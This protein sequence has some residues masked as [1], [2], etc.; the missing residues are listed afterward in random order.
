MRC[1]R[2]ARSRHRLERHAFFNQ[3]VSAGIA[4]TDL[5][6]RTIQRLLRIEFIIDHGADDLEV[7]L[8]LHESAHDTEAGPEFA[9]IQRQSGDDGVVRSFA[10]RQAMR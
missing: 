7:P 5:P 8:G 2:S 4:S 3:E 6:A 9:V 10:R 1:P